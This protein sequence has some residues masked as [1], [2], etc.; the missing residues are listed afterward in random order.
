MN[1]TN[2]N[3]INLSQDFTY[4]KKVLSWILINK[5][6][7]YILAIIYLKVVYN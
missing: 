1:K 3:I 4:Y 5:K 7:V 2:K 6:K